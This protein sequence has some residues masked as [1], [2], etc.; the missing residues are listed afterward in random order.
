M[1]NEIQR[2]DPEVPIE[3][4]VT[5][6][7]S[8]YIGPGFLEVERQTVFRRSWQAV[9]RLDQVPGNGDYFTGQFM[10][11]PYV[12][13]RDHGGVLRAFYNVCRHHAAGVAQETGSLE[14]F[15]CPY[16]S[17]TYRL[18][19]RL[20]RAPR[21]GG[22]R[23]FDR[24]EF[25]LIPLAVDSWGPLVFVHFGPE[26]SRLTEELRPLHRWLV[27]TELEGLTFVARRT[28]EL[29][30]NWKVYVDNYL[31]GGYHVDTLHRGLASQLDLSSYETRV[32]GRTCIQT[33]TSGGSG[34]EV[35]CDFGERVGGGAVY[36][37]VYPNLM[38][39]RYG[40]V[41]D[42]NWTLPLGPDRCAVVFDYFFENPHD[43]R[44]ID[45]CLKASHQVQEEDIEVCESVQRGLGSTAYQVGRYAPR[46]E[47]G[48]HHFHRLLASDL[49]RSAE[50][51]PAPG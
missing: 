29:A 32:E 34:P 48:E 36:A 40:P 8:W 51:V 6:P 26:P 7:S 46:V 3:E 31:D 4:A 30:C 10:G 17:W 18:D 14:E 37:W 47:M 41:L 24:E 15:V 39:N 2:F 11:E 19:G 13:V 43:A 21:M 28:Y 9:G 49:R 35:G 25:N 23:C 38:L 45:D 27:E 22:V 20:K 5:P 1:L 50:G 12:V 44:F 33:V 16:H 42:T